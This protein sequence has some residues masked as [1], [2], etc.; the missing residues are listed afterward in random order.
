MD[1]QPDAAAIAPDLNVA[2]VAHGAGNDAVL[3]NVSTG[4]PSFLNRVGNITSPTGVDYDPVTQDFLIVS[5]AS[6]TVTQLNVT[7]TGSNTYSLLQS[8]IRVGVNPTSLAYDFQSGTLL[9][10]NTASH[11]LSVVDLAKC[12][13]TAATTVSCTTTSTVRDVLPF[14]GTVQYALAI[15]PWLSYFVLSDSSNN[16]IVILPTPR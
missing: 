9:T 11:T 7:P 3:V 8:S 14:S 4:E 10:L 2:V 16:R 6:N 5:S 12:G 13:I 1:A 15:H